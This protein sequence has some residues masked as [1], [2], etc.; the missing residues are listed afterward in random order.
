MLNVNFHRYGE[1]LKH[2]RSV[3]KCRMCMVDTSVYDTMFGFSLGNSADCCLLIARH[4]GNVEQY[5]NELKSNWEYEYRVQEALLNEYN[6]CKL[7][8][9]LLWNMK[10]FV[11]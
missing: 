8:G 7:N 10:S 3:F 5:T 2:F 1:A 11:C 4:W 6:K 9:D